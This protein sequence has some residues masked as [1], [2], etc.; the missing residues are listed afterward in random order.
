MSDALPKLLDV[1]VGVVLS[2]DGQVLI[3]QRLAGKPYAGWW[4]F[5]GG[6]VESGE[7][8][9]QALARELNEELGLESVESTPW[10]VRG[11]DYPHA[12]VRLFFR[13]VR[14]WRGEPLSREGQALVWQP[15]DAIGVAPLLP[16]SLGPI[17]WLRL[18]PFYRISCAADIGVAA[19][20]RSLEGLLR[21]QPVFLQLREP[22]LGDAEFERLFGRLLRLRETC[23]LR[24]IVSSRHPAAFWEAADGVHL[25]GRDLAA[26][27]VRPKLTWVGA[28]CH[29]FDDL[30]CADRLGCDFAVFGPVAAT[31][32]HP[33]AASMGFAG[34]AEQIA[35]TPIPVYALGGLTRN[36][37]PAAESAGAHGVAMMRAAWP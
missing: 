33:G 28:S 1:A 10:I 9:E 4:E 29:H 25:T 31:E 13:R 27:T 14:R 11:H 19:F 24:I 34:L 23:P 35:E 8:V 5:P 6:K 3:G 30:I 17:G 21:T 37:L 15:I 36:D 12:T 18:P 26:A 7:S 2:A 16:A 20:E 22:L 32:S